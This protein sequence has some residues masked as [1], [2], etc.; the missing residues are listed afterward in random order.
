MGFDLQAHRGGIALTVE[1]TLAAFARALAVGVTT[2][3]LDVQ[4]TKDGRVVVAHDRDPMPRKCL[5]TAAAFPGDPAFPYV[6]DETY[7]VD[8]TL[9]QV[10]TIDVG[11]QRHPSFPG[12]QL[13]PG[14]RMP[15]LSEVFDLV[16][17]AGADDVRLCVE[18]KVE[19][20][21]PT[22][23]APRE[24]FVEGVVG[25]ARAAGM[26]DRVTI[27][28]FDWGTL[29]RIREL[30][31]RL[32]I[33]ALTNGAHFLQPGAAAASPWLGG[34]DIDDFTGTLQEKYVAAAASFGADIVSPVHGDPQTASAA[35]PDYLPFTTP[36]L[37]EAA[38]AAGMLVVPWTV[39][40]AA[41][42]RHLIEIGVDGVI[43]NRPDLAREVM[44]ECGLELPR[45]Y[46]RP[47][48]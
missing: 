23:T 43:T 13:A 9:A 5:D 17:D 39:D 4:V 6:R 33:A 15:L 35:D 19:A 37:V 20:A 3:E 29:M 40:D 10:R 48:A 47:R 7:V 14:A 27:E 12:Q 1:N 22:R 16:R 24:A 38:H 32:P 41:T 31:P 30:E 34:L 44:T 18:T 42:L 46:D 36:A 45:P 2:L 21:D 25:E 8:L 28:S 11:S 26:V